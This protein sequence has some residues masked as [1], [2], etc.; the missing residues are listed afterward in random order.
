MSNVLDHCLQLSYLIFTK[1]SSDTSSTQM[2]N[3]CKNCINNYS[4]PPCTGFS[5]DYNCSSPGLNT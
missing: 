4:I 5:K 2:D 1:S 3:N